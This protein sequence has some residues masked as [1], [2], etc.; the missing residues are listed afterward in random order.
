MA[1][2]NALANPGPLGL[3]GF[4]LTTVLLSL[5]N[6]HILPQGGVSVVIPL[7][8]AYGGLIQLIAGILEF[9]TGNTFG[10]VAFTSYGAFW[11]WFALLLLLS[12]NGLIDL[13]ASG[14]TIGI[15]LILWG[16][17]TLY[18]WVGTFRLNRALW[19]VFLTL[20]ITFFLLGVG[21]A[22]GV[23]TISIIGGWVGI[24]CGG[25]AMYTSFAEVTNHCYKR[26]VLPVGPMAPREE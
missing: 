25:L 18:M 4:G 16:F 6:A 9:R 3:V 19:W 24:L 12:G 21:D 17:F 8:L 20:W 11:W 23:P 10:V 7:A 15:A 22:I 5:I 2:N 26:V 1:E 13:K 14:P